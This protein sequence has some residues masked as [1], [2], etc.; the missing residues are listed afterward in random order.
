M[1]E[2]LSDR[3]D[4]IETKLA[5]LEDFLN[6]LQEELVGRNADMD[7]LITE[8][9]AIKERIRFISRHIEEIPNQ[10]PPHY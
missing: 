9:S 6:R 5:Y 8:N 7:K 10:R 1:P 4:K 3:L 2:D